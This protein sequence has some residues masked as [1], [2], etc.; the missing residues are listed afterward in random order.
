MVK[1]AIFVCIYLTIMIDSLLIENVCRSVIQE[2]LGISDEVTELANEAFSLLSYVYDNTPRWMTHNFGGEQLMTKHM[3][4]DLA[5]NQDMVDLGLSK[6]ISS[7]NIIFYGYDQRKYSYEEYID[8]LAEVSNK[9]GDRLLRLAFVPSIREIKL[10]IPFPIDGNIEDD[11]K[12]D[13]MSSIRHEVEHAWQSY[14]RGG[15]KVTSQYT[16]S[17]ARN[18]WN[19]DK[20]TALPLLRYYLKHCYYALDPDEIDA[21]IHE[22]WYELES[23]SG[24]LED[25]EGYKFMLEVQKDYKWVRNLFESKNKFDIKYYEMERSMFPQL[26]RDEVGLN[27]PSQWFRYC[28][29]GIRKFNEQIRRVAGRQNAVSGYQGNGSFKNYAKGEIPQ[30]E[31]FRIKKENPSLW[32]KLVNRFMKR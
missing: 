23:G 5:K 11:M 21:K 18:D 28:E 29:K 7:F 24:K 4:V 15:T 2:Y 10:F 13:V 19:S 27:S 22:I 9:C 25:C 12:R 14:K 3:I 30:G 1:N 26:V 32:R 31:L 17:L 6:V 20:N 8:Y 16:K